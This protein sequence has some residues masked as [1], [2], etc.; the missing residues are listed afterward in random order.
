VRTGQPSAMAVHI[1]W[2]S[3]KPFW[4][5][6]TRA[7]V[8]S[9]WRSWPHR[10]PEGVVR[11]W[12]VG[13]RC[14]RGWGRGMSA[15][16]APAIPGGAGVGGWPAGEGEGK[17]WAIPVGPFALLVSVPWPLIPC[18]LYPCSSSFVRFLAISFFCPSPLSRLLTGSRVRFPFASVRLHIALFLRV[19]LTR[20]VLHIALFPYFPPL[21]SLLFQ[22]DFRGIGTCL[23]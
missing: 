13:G 1:L 14:W 9:Y 12:G 4:S 5:D 11:G 2:I 16:R 20:L 23:W 8:G 21:S 17:G 19:A 3:S 6:R 22:H 15:A 18:Y 7:M 10:V